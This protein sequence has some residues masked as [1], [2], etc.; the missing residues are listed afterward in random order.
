MS[1]GGSVNAGFAGFGIAAQMSQLSSVILG[2]KSVYMYKG[3][4]ALAPSARNESNF[5]APVNGV[6]NPPYTTGLKI[7]FSLPKTST[8][9]GKMWAEIS[10][11]AAQ[12][13]PAYTP[14]VPANPLANPQ[15]AAVAAVGTPQAE[16]VKNVGDLIFE[17]IL[18]RYGST[19]LQQYDSEA[20]VFLR[21]L[22]KNNINLEYINVEV[23]GNLPPGGN[24]EQTLIDALYQ[25]VTLRHPVEHIWFT[26]H[27][28]EHWMPEALALEGQ[29]EFTLRALQDLIVTA[30]GTNSVFTGGAA[31]LPGITDLRL[32]YQEITLSAAEKENRL[33]LYKSPEG[34]VN[35]FQDW[36]AQPAFRIAGTAAGGQLNFNVPLQNFRLDMV[37]V[38]FTVRIAEDT[39]AVAL[40]GYV[41]NADLRGWRGSRVESNTSTPS[42]LGGGGGHIG[43]H[44]P[45]VSYKLTAG[46]KDLQNAI[47]ELWSRTHVRKQ[48]HA[49]SQTGGGV[50]MIS[51]AIYPEDTKN[52]TGHASASVLGALALN[53]VVNNPGAHIVLQVDTWEKGYNVIQA[54]AGGISKVLH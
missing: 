5:L 50:Y 6:V 9:I 37:E 44:F 25:G 46:G 54:R 29:L 17:T 42:L 48:Y 4:Q 3:S 16:Y 45:I 41:Y 22:T 39:G 47:P 28:D 35:L 30:S 11:S 15:T 26:Q 49:D 36:E 27:Q 31:V 1:G 23:L 38:F 12:T 32:R 53:L 21:Q 19:V 34:M 14:A 51:F 33:R 43:V 10:L 24:T 13:N 8:L 18:L 40:P 20:Q 7:V 52:A 2:T